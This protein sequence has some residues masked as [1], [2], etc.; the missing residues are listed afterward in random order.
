MA[1]NSSWIALL[2]IVAGGCS[3]TEPTSTTAQPLIGFCH[4][5]A[6]DRMMTRLVTGSR[7]D[8]F[9]FDTLARTIALVDDE[10]S[11]TGMA[12]DGLSSSCGRQPAGY[13]ARMVGTGT[14]NGTAGYRFALHASQIPSD[15]ATPETGFVLDSASIQVTS[16]TGDIVYARGGF[17]DAPFTVVEARDPDDHDC[18]VTGSATLATGDRVAIS[19]ATAPGSPTTGSLQLV[20]APGGG[21][22]VRINA[23]FGG[24]IC[25]SDGADLLD[26]YGTATVDGAGGYWARVHIQS[27]RSDE[28]DFL[29]FAVR[30]TQGTLVFFTEGNAP[31]DSFPVVIP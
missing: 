14:W 8:R 9:S 22:R 4:M 26:A 18:S 17:V 11:F 30:D 6:T 20:S 24:L 27:F 25:R 21:R 5:S 1:F 2:L 13:V 23:D 28:E 3:S 31:Q 16:P 7:S 10:G 15:V 29:Q 19:V 12:T